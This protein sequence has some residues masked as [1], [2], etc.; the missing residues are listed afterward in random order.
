MRAWGEYAEKS[1]IVVHVTHESFMQVQRLPEILQLLHT[2]LPE[3]TEKHEHG[4]SHAQ[5]VAE[6]ARDEV[7]SGFT[8][9]HAHALLGLWGALECLVEDL[10]IGAL[11][12]DP[13]ILST[14]AFDKIK[15]PIGIINV[16]DTREI[17]AAVLTEASRT[18]AADLGKG[19]SRFDRLLTMV[20]LGGATPRQI[21]DAIFEAQQIRNVWA[22]RAG[23]ADE[24]FLAACPGLGFAVGDRV[25]LSAP[26]FLHL[27]HG[28]HMFGAVLIGRMNARAGQ[29]PVRLPECAGYEGVFSGEDATDEVE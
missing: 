15:L 16:P 20:G 22:H 27:M 9:V 17:Y 11:E 18:S 1:E 6:Y 19:V 12:E 21:K 2:A 26:H 5:R 13:A 3:T 10:F 7:E 29:T 4:L 25:A 23:I 14:P 28:L 24:R 8:F